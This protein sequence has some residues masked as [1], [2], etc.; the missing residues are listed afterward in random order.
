MIQKTLQDFARPPGH[1]YE[2]Q[3]P[4]R[5]PCAEMPV[6]R[7]SDSRV[8]TMPCFPIL[9]TLHGNTGEP[10]Q[11]LLVLHTNVETSRQQWWLERTI[12]F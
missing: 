10:G 5:F 2:P 9:S 3:L 12:F 8:Y 11:P 4:L 6:N 1:H 7:M